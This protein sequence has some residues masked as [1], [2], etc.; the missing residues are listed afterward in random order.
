VRFGLSFLPDASPRTKSPAAYFTDALSLVRLADAS[1]FHSVKMTEHYLHPYGGY[2]PN[3]LAFLAAVAA[4]TKRVRLMTGCILP[5]FHHPIQIAADAAMVDAISDGRVELGFARAYLPYEFEAFGVPLD[6]S[7]ARYVATIET[8]VRLWTEQNVTVETPF[9]SFQNATSLPRPTQRPHPPVWVAA[10]MSPESFTW[11]GEKGFFLLVTPPVSGLASLPD[12]I[13]RYRSA[14]LA[15]HGESG[16]QPQVAISLPLYVAETDQQAFTEGDQFLRRYFEVWGDAARAWDRTESPAYRGYTG[17]SYA[18]LTKDPEAMRADGSA[19]M[20]S[21]ARVAEQ[22]HWLWE[23]LQVDQILW[24]VDYGAMPGE[25]AHRSLRL[26][27][28]ETL[29]RLS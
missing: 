29:P 1:G 22:T 15:A 13:A 18:I 10:V 21:P 11:I 14:F 28:E 2:C 6:E 20:G 16:R 3:P 9:F 26:F 19:V 24:Q 27:I 4:Q 8:V 17:M 25:L 23:H 12:L 7:R 5:A